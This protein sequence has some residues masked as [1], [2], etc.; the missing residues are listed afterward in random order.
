[1]SK[2]LLKTIAKSIPVTH[3]TDYRTWLAAVYV[4]AK[5]SDS[6]YSYTKFSNDL[7]LGSS[8]AH[9]IVS[10]KRDLTEKTGSKIIESF[11]LT[12]KQ[13]KYFSALITYQRS[14]STKDREQAFNEMMSLKSEV[15][16]T[17]LSKNQ[18][19][20]FAD[21][22][23][24]AILELLR[25]ADASDDPQWLNKIINPKVSVPQI[26]RSLKLLT[27]LGYLKV[28]EKIGRLY[29]TEATISTGNEAYGMAMVS[30]HQQMLDV[31]KQSI[32]D[33]EPSKRE[34][35]ATTMAI[36][37][38]LRQQFK[39]DIISLRKRMIQLANEVEDANEIVQINMQLF[40][41]AQTKETQD[42]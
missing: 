31:A 6:S 4:A 12:G 33:V 21:W 39:Q 35:S 26:K 34:I 9:L 2:T 11:K 41:I 22:Y 20:F 19:E 14:R 10:G 37:T 36:T 38:S 13:R 30:Y 7:E 24:A 32:N 23:N 25:L 18:L 40:P 5:S 8:N 16:P 29:P 3:H 27:N 17:T 15:L 1:M 28:D 42:D